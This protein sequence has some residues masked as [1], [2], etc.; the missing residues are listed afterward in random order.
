MPGDG[1]DS[2]GPWRES[3]MLRPPTAIALPMAMTMMLGRWCEL[4]NVCGWVR[5]VPA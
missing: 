5:V 3:C 4:S 2:V 1:S